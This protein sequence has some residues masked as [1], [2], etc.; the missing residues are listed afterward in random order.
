MHIQFEHTPDCVVAAFL[1]LDAQLFR[2]V[3]CNV[4]VSV[5]WTDA[6]VWGTTWIPGAKGPTWGIDI[7]KGV[8]DMRMLLHTMAHEMCHVAAKSWTQRDCEGEDGH[9]PT[10]QSWCWFCL[11]QLPQL[12]GFDQVF[13]CKSLTTSYAPVFYCQPC[14]AFAVTN[15][16][17]NSCFSSTV[18]P[19]TTMA[20]HWS[21][22]TQSADQPDA[23]QRGPLL[24]KR[25]AA[26]AAKEPQGNTQGCVQCTH[27]SSEIEKCREVLHRQWL[28][29]Q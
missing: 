23:E 16:C 17:P 20:Q 6:D 28:R 24:K 4:E 12:F 25:R 19:L 3:L 2:G 26:A 7:G 5:A 1:Y 14:K 9:G 21:V 11:Q 18:C 29:W 22:P 15:R 10:W 27:R 8:V 13:T